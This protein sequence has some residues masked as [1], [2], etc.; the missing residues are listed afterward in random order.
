MEV[1]RKYKEQTKLGVATAWGPHG[2]LSLV[3]YG[4]G[5]ENDFT[6]LNG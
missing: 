1:S 6:F 3:L 4:P 2:A 5:V